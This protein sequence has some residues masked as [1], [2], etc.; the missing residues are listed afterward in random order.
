MV[1]LTLHAICEHN[2]RIRFEMSYWVVSD[3]NW[4]SSTQAQTY[5]SALMTMHK[6][7]NQSEHVKNY[8]PQ[9]LLLVG[10]PQNRQPLVDLANLITRNNSL[11]MCA[12]ISKVR[13][14]PTK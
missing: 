9:V 7:F 6:L 14:H 1:C 12:E 13:K 10:Q 8:Q 2:T 5:K 3:V 11:L 4:G